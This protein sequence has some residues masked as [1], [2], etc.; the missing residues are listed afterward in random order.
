MNR[1]EFLTALGTPLLAAACQHRKG[2]EQVRT[3][4]LEANL[5]TEL[6]AVGAYKINPTV[7]LF[8]QR[9]GATNTVLDFVCFWMICTHARCF[10]DYKASQAQFT[11]PC[12]GSIFDQN[13]QSLQG[14][15]AAQLER[16][17]FVI[18]ASVLRVFA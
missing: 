7:G 4:L 2:D 16:K 15:A 17:Q 14:P 1:K 5:A 13:G 10:V 9:T 12:H 11:C 6:L 8:V 3:V 18:A